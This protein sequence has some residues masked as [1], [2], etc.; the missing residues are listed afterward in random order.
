MPPLEETGPRI[1]IFERRLALSANMGADLFLNALDAMQSDEIGSTCNPVPT[2]M[3][4]FELSA[5]PATADPLSPSTL[6]TLLDQAALIRDQY[7]LTGAGQ[8]V[9]V[10]DSGITWDHVALGEGYGPGYRVVGGWDFAENDANPYDDGPAGFHG[11]HV[12]GLIAG[13]SDSFMGIAPGADLVGLRVFDDLGRGSLDWI[14]SALQW[15]YANRNEFD[16]PITTVNLSIGALLPDALSTDVHNQLEDELLQL[17]NANIVVVAAAGNQ[18]DADNP[19]QLNYPAS[20]DYAWAVASTDSNQS[21]SSFSQRDDAILATDGRNIRS[22]VP[23]HVLGMDGDINDYHYATGTSMSSPQVAAASVLLRQAVMQQGGDTSPDHLLSILK[24]TATERQDSITGLSYLDVNLTA[25]IASVM[26]GSGSGEG[27]LNPPLQSQDLGIVEWDE[28]EL[29]KDTSVHFTAARDGLFSFAIDSEHR[30]TNL[31]IVDSAGQS[32]WNGTAPAN[33][34]IDLPVSANQTLTLYTHDATSPTIQLANIISLKNGQLSLNTGPDNPDV[35]ID[36][37]QSF[38]A[39]VGEFH[40]NFSSDQVSSGIIDGGSGA[41]HVSIAGS[42]TAS[43]LTLNPYA[44]GTLSDPNLQLALRGFEDVSFD[45]RGGGDRVF[46]YDTVGNDE[47]VASP[48]T[49]RL[50]GVGF[51]YEISG[52]ERTYVHA[53]A[54]GQDIAFLNDSIGNDVLA[55]RPQF[56]SLRGGDFFN[57]AYGF[58]RVYAYA[59]SGGFDRA[60]LYDSAGDDR[61]TAN[62]ATAIISGSGYYVQARSFDS[63]TG[64]A[65][66]GGNDLATLYSDNSADGRWV[67]TSDSVTLRANDGSERIARGF[68]RAETYQ[69]GIP[70]QVQS[71]NLFTQLQFHERNILDSIFAA[72][73]E[74]E[75]LDNF[76]T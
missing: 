27:P 23:D 45:G 54:G 60:D 8:T 19:D 26:S 1:E 25:A 69:G 58:E 42:S 5:L 43:R 56:V 37:N 12:S 72:D 34:Q 21:L 10:I 33:G 62:S 7:G 38:S 22:T 31:I 17:H 48:T 3:A 51:R 68:E 75:M 64:H 9:A 15:V 13:S 39:T 35:A 59:T 11:T 67:Q 20:S 74:D 52:A 70:I 47:L 30:N 46:L 76:S 29:I 41:D 18:F 57:I 66:A 65:V 14:E 53:T 4:A 28:I 16:S 24:D 71:A 40:Y 61:F 36:L 63:V 44:D 6:P 2:G 73:D 32:L 49:A 50:E 55:V